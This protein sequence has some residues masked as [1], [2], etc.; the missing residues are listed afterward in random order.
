[1]ASLLERGYAQIV[2]QHRVDDLARLYS[3]LARVGAL[4]KLKLAFKENIKSTGEALVM[5]AEKVRFLTSKA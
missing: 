4:E 3:L 2:S 5:D 1:M